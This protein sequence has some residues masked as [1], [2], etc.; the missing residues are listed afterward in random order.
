MRFNTYVAC[1][2]E[3]VRHLNSGYL[4]ITIA[5]LTNQENAEAI[6]SHQPKR[7]QAKYALEKEEVKNDLNKLQVFLMAV[8]QLMKLMAPMLMSSRTSVTLSMLKTKRKPVIQT[9]VLSAPTS[10]TIGNPIEASVQ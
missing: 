1:C 3:W 2:Q 4:N 5:R 8:T 6:F 9:A 7:H 10:T